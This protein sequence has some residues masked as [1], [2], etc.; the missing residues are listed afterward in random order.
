MTA[1]SLRITSGPSYGAAYDSSNALKKAALKDPVRGV[2]SALR[3]GKLLLTEAQA[4]MTPRTGS[5]SAASFSAAPLTYG[6][7]VPWDYVRILVRGGVRQ[8]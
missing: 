8:Q 7:H 4:V 5:L 1:T 3:K 2:A 6:A